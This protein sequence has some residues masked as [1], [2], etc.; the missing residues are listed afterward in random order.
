VVHNPNRRQ[1]ELWQELA[2][3]QQ[4]SYRLMAPLH[5]SIKGLIREQGLLRAQSACAVLK[6]PWCEQW[7]PRTKGYR[8]ILQLRVLEQRPI[9]ETMLALSEI[10]SK[11]QAQSY[12]SWVLNNLTNTLPAV[13][14]L[15]PPKERKRRGEG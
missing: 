1:L 4:V 14:L 2:G 5:E 8:E 12:C 3:D 9:R 7:L 15:R 13:K 6:Q 11:T 10:F